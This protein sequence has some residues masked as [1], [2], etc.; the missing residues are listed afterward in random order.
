MVS[1]FFLILASLIS[2]T[3]GADEMATLGRLSGLVESQCRR[4]YGIDT[5]S[6]IADLE[7]KDMSEVDKLACAYPFAFEKVQARLKTLERLDPPSAWGKQAYLTLAARIYNFDYLTDTPH[8]GVS[9][10]IMGV[11]PDLL[12][13]HRI[14]RQVAP[15]ALAF[16]Y[17][18]L[19][20]SNADLPMAAR[21]AAAGAEE[22]TPW[23]ATLR[24]ANG[25]DCYGPAQAACLKNKTVALQN[26]VQAIQILSKNENL[27]GYVTQYSLTR[28]ATELQSAPLIRIA[29]DIHKSIS[30][31]P[32]DYILGQRTAADWWTVRPDLRDTLDYLAAS[33]Q[34]VQTPANRMISLNPLDCHIVYGS[35][36]A[37]ASED[38][39]NTVRQALMSFNPL[40]AAVRSN[41]G[42]KADPLQLQALLDR[43]D[44]AQLSRLSIELNLH[45]LLSRF[46][47]YQT[48]IILLS[49]HDDALSNATLKAASRRFA[50]MMDIESVIHEVQNKVRSSGVVIKPTSSP[51]PQQLVDY[52]QTLIKDDQI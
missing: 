24:Q 38:P 47:A 35:L 46:Q 34:D 21:I 15:Y 27:N 48:H 9:V 28:E 2:I 14:L 10:E 25:T 42:L 41:A 22:L 39:S 37:L 23:S 18:K 52:I 32:V 7:Q 50:L 49:S 6:S 16:V 45:G 51:V 36:F 11:H 19:T 13:L 26:L 40:E 20:S 3:A 4:F 12:I 5:N 1:R 44:C 30:G 29:L 43:L 33:D 31:V 17:P 8:D